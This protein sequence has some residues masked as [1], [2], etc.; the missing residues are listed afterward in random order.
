[1]VQ[2]VTSLEAYHYLIFC[3]IRL[4]ETGTKKEKTELTVRISLKLLRKLYSPKQFHKVPVLELW[5][6]EEWYKD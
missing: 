3:S 6:K 5:L 4:A 1:M 2:A